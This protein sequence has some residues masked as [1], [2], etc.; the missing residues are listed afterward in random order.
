MQVNPEEKKE[1]YVEFTVRIDTKPKIYYSAEA[2]AMKRNYI[3]MA[4]DIHNCEEKIKEA[5]KN[6]EE[7]KLKIKEEVDFCL[8]SMFI[9]YSREI[10]RKSSTLDTLRLKLLKQAMSENTV[11]IVSHSLPEMKVTD[12]FN[13]SVDEPSDKIEA[14]PDSKIEVYDTFVP[15][16][17]IDEKW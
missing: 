1:E 14:L 2:N 17:K 9:Q 8:C 6:L 13:F 4:G 16:D 3:R 15:V 5:E 10:G 12:D 11:K 7:I